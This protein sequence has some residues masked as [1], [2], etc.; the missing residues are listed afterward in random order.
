MGFLY[1]LEH[2][3]QCSL[4]RLRGH[5]DLFRA[6]ELTSHL[7]W[8]PTLFLGCISHVDSSICSD[9]EVGCTTRGMNS[10]PLRANLFLEVSY[11]SSTLSPSYNILPQ[12]RLPRKEY[13]DPKLVRKA[14]QE[15]AVNCTFGVLMSQILVYRM[16]SCELDV[17]CGTSPSYIVYKIIFK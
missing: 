2:C 7:R 15:L 8:L 1:K 6:S 16:L 10:E 3:S 4:K 13:S 5:L 14:L 12:Y 17:I 11:M 9:V